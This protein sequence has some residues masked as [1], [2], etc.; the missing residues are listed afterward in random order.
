MDFLFVIFYFQD[1]AVPRFASNFKNTKYMLVHGTGDGK[2]STL[3]TH[4]WSALGQ[5]L[6][7]GESRD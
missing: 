3:V 6:Q 5:K 2:T 4:S 1:A 7:D